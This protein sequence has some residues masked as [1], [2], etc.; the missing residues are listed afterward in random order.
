M[1]QSGRWMIAVFVSL[2]S[3]LNDELLCSPWSNCL[4]CWQGKSRRRRRKDEGEPDRR[5]RM[6]TE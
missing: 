1:L 2:A 6:K 3:L 4:L 5:K